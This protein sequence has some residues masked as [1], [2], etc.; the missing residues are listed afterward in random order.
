LNDAFWL[1]TRHALELLKTIFDDPAA[2][3]VAGLLGRI[4]AGFWIS[5]M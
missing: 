4:I 5:P 3:H 2:R 1:E